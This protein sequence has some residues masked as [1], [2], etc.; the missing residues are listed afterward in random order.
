MVAAFAF[1]SARLAG[2]TKLL[3]P[4][5]LLEVCLF[6][7]EERNRELKWWLVY[8]RNQLQMATLCCNLGAI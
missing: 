8:F 1:Q 6:D 4:L 2:G 5:P 7:V 3:L